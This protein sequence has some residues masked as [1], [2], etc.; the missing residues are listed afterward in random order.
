VG[1][2]LAVVTLPITRGDDVF[3]EAGAR[4]GAVAFL[5]LVAGI[6]LARPA[7]VPLAAALAGGV[8][9]VELAIADAPLDVAAPAVAA[10]LLLCT[11]LAYWS[12]EERTRWRGDAGD[13]LRR[14]AVVALLGVAALFVAALLLALVDAV[15]ARGLALD[16][17]GAIAAVTVLA[18]VLVVA[19]GQR[20][21]SS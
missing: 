5:A 20:Q 16:L 14:A 21:S 1:C 3:Q 10:A 6:V 13:G 7:L 4:V 12:L 9:G 18:T 2:L 8:Y 15:R 19:R 17:L 11:E